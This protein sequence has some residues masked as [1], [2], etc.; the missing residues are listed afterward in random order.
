MSAPW[1]RDPD[2]WKRTP[3]DD[4]ELEA[5]CRRLAAGAEITAAALEDLADVARR[6]GT[7]LEELARALEILAEELDDDER[8]R[9]G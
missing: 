6:A 8:P 4:A 1:E 7:S 3:E 9:A 5:A 2:W